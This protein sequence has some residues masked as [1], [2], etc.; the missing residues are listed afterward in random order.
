M[1]QPYQT[2]RSISKH[3]VLLGNSSLYLIIFSTNSS[4]MFDIK[5]DFISPGK[6]T[7]LQCIIARGCA[8]NKLSISW[9]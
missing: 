2:F 9:K 3:L 6:G 1:G 4:I 8:G 7:K 5:L